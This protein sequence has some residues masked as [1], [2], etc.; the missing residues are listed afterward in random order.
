MPESAAPAVAPPR[1]PIAGAGVPAAPPRDIL[2][3]IREWLF[4]GNTIVKPASASSSSARLPRQ[5]RER[6]RAPAGRGAP[7]GDRRRSPWS[8]SA[9]AGA[10][11][12]APD[13]AQVLQGGAVA[14][15]YLTLFAAFRY[16]ASLP[17]RRRS[18]SW[19]RSPRSPLRSRCCRTRGRSPSSARSAASRRRYRLDGSNNDVALFAYYLVLDAGIA[20]VAWSKTWRLLNL[21]GFVATFIVATAWGVLQYR[22]EDYATSQAF[23]IAF[24]LLFVV[25]LVLPARRCATIRRTLAR[26]A[27]PRGVGEQH[28]AV[29][30]ADVTFALEY[31]L[32]AERRTERRLPRS[33]SPAST[34]CSQLDAA[35]AR[36]RHHLRGDARDR[37][38]LP[39]ARDPVR[40]RRAQHRGAWTLEGAGLVWI[41]FRQRR[42]LP[43]AF[44]YLLLVLAGLA[45]LIGHERYGTPTLIFN[46]YLFNG[47]MAAAASLAAAAFVDRGRRAGALKPARTRANRC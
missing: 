31:G 45:M 37:D 13:Y 39:H 22:P 26:E 2:A 34:S 10:C 1:A 12:V 14:V 44:G 28:L 46:A 23:L 27:A 35:Q 11:A 15:L 18:S 20:A 24:F 25:I 21:V 41:G 7:G 29:R 38:R 33:P 5:I 6:A 30:P 16:Y 32:V 36:A 42:G 9:S 47:L 4:G 40:A 8:C 19:S 17:R 43:R 3:P